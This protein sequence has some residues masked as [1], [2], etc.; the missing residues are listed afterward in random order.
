MV[1][2]IQLDNISAGVNSVQAK[3]SAWQ[4]G[5]IQIQNLKSEILTS[6]WMKYRWTYVKSRNVLLNSSIMNTI[7]STCT[8]IVRRTRRVYGDYSD[9]VS[10]LKTTSGSRADKFI[11]RK[12]TGRQSSQRTMRN[13]KHFWHNT[14]GSN[15]N[16]WLYSRDKNLCE[17]LH[18]MSFH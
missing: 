14:N 1:A 3:E 8:T 2:L 4:A 6:K 16:R 12:T 15:Q 7:E 17:T 18:K 5:K 9:R 13:G 10:Q 11:N